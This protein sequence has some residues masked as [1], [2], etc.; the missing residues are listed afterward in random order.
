MPVCSD[1][2]VSGVVSFKCGGA[3]IPL[4]GGLEGL[5]CRGGGVP[6]AL[7][8]E[9]TPLVEAALVTVLRS[10][11]VTAYF[12]SFSCAVG[13]V[14]SPPVNWRELVVFFLLLL[15]WRATGVGLTSRLPDRSTFSS[16]SMDFDVPLLCVISPSNKSWD[17]ADSTVEISFVVPFELPEFVG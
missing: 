5:V 6:A 4:R 12:G 16:D 3:S 10:L 14:T 17:S 2:D 13:M 15:C 7:L 8:V 1:S 9:I 11:S